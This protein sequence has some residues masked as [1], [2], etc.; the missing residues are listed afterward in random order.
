MQPRRLLECRDRLRS[1]QHIV[2]AAAPPGLGDDLLRYE[3]LAE[4]SSDTAVA[5]YRL[6]A[7]RVSPS[8]LATIIYTSGTTGEPKGVMLT[9]SN[10]SS[11]EEA[12]ASGNEMTPSDV[13]VSFLPLSHPYQRVTSQ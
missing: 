8:Q 1:V 5:E 9:H 6:R 10:F 11:N 2:C 7:G 3:T 12:S 13:A 4:G